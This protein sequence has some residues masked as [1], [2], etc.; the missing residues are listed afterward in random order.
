MVN[1]QANHYISL[2]CGLIYFFYF[3]YCF[4][5]EWCNLFFKHLWECCNNLDFILASLFVSLVYCS[6]FIWEEVLEIRLSYLKPFGFWCKVVLRTDLVSFSCSY[7]FEI[8]IISAL[9]FIIPLFYF[10]YWHCPIHPPLGLIARPFQ[11][12]SEPNSSFLLFIIWINF[13]S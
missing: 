2:C 12:V 4:V 5:D 6:L 13:L 9:W 11:V 7:Y 1:T 10:L 3:P 8:V